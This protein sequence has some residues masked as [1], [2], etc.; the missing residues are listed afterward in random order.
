MISR[1]EIKILKK[2]EHIKK[3]NKKIV[4]CHGVFDLVHLKYNILKV[5]KVWDHFFFCY[6]RQI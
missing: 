3:K 6:T 2:I 5:Q 4:L 1:N